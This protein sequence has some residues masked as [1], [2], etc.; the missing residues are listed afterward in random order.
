MMTWAFTLKFFEGH[1][2]NN[3]A[4][5]QRLED[6]APRTDDQELYLRQLSYTFRLETLVAFEQRKLTAITLYLD[7]LAP[8][9]LPEIT[10]T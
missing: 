8:I 5:V 9:N 3:F 2:I 4:F 1:G 6:T 7:G 10:T